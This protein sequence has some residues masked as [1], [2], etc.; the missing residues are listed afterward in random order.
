VLI[1]LLVF[2]CA[3]QRSVGVGKGIASVC[4][5]GAGLEHDQMILVLCVCL[6]PPATALAELGGVAGEIPCVSR[7]CESSIRDRV[8]PTSQRG[9][10]SVQTRLGLS[11]LFVGAICIGRRKM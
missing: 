1:L 10:L 3:Y 8:F 7:G 6:W 11:L 5:I 4:R 9:V 2:Q